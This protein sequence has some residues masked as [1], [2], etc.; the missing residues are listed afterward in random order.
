MGVEGG[1]ATVWAIG[2]GHTERMGCV[3]IGNERV[4]NMGG[5]GKRDDTSDFLSY[6]VD[7]K[8]AEARC[9]AT[10]RRGACMFFFEG[11][12]ARHA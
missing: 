12:G 1:E 5:R 3:Q 9:E 4:W 8:E 2:V 11:S 10:T 6:I 7:A